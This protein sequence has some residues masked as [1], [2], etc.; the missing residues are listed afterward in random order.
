M[1]ESIPGYGDPECY[2]CPIIKDRAMVGLCN[3]M[4]FYTRQQEEAAKKENWAAAIFWE[5]KQ[6]QLALRTLKCVPG[7][8]RV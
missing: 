8:N 6:N 2:R 7:G 4:V 3:A 1:A 5:N